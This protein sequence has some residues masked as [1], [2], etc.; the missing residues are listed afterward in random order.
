MKL[1][2]SIFFFCFISN[3][4]GIIEFCG[5][6]LK[7]FNTCFNKKLLD[8]DLNDN[9]EFEKIINIELWNRKKIPMRIEFDELIF[10]N[11]DYHELYFVLKHFGRHRNQNALLKNDS[12][13]LW[14]DFCTNKGWSVNMTSIMLPNNVEVHGFDS[15]WKIKGTILSNNDNI[16]PNVR[17]EIQL[18]Q[19]DLNQTLP[20]ILKKYSNSKIY[21]VS[22][23]CG[24]YNDTIQVLNHISSKLIKGII[25]FILYHLSI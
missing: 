1:L 3:D 19:G 15:N 2:I 10:N 25:L 13:E 24:S 6:K 11:N 22:F 9:I 4:A 5:D 17:D 16:F 23:N 12:Q 14:L 18:H 21:G 7:S 8:T 20:L